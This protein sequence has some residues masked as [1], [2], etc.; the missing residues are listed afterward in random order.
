VE[1]AEVGGDQAGAALHRGASARGKLCRAFVR[2][3]LESIADTLRAA[4]IPVETYPERAGIPT[5]AALGK[6]VH[7]PR[8]AHM[9]ASI[10][11]EHV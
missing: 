7:E 3:A 10:A 5:A 6:A 11:H 1:V 2:E 8:E 9:P 4:Q